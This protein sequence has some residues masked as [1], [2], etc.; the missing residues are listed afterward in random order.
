ME[1]TPY[2]AAISYMYESKIRKKIRFSGVEKE[3]T[4]SNQVKRVVT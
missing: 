3:V 4:K 2:L 1:E